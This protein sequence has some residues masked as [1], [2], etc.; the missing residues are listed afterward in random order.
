MKLL[1]I[2]KTSIYIIKL[3]SIRKRDPIQNFQVCVIILFIH[4]TS[5]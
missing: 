4:Y 5:N 3:V 1:K 2:L